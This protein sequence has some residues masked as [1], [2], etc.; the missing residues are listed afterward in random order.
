MQERKRIWVESTGFSSQVTDSFDSS[1]DKTIVHGALF[2][3]RVI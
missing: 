3:A 1:A 2:T